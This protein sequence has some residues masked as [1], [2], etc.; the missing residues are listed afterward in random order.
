VTGYVKYFKAD[1]HFGH[2]IP[3]GKEDDRSS[4]VFFHED[5]IEPGYPIPGKGAEV[6]YELV[7]NY[8]FGPH[9]LWV[10]PLSRRNYAPVSELRKTVARGHG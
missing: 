10:R 3:E 9:A 1:R 5:S 7:P 2:I 8:P 6:E 4:H